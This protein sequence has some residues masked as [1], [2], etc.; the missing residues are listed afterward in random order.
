MLDKDDEHDDMGYSHY[1]ISA[2]AGGKVPP[3]AGGEAGEWWPTSGY[4]WVR[5]RSTR[6]FLACLEI[7]ASF[8]KSFPI[9]S[10]MDGQT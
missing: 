7:W 9:H 5:A 3:G 1:R 10:S 8:S 2:R 4:S 6:A